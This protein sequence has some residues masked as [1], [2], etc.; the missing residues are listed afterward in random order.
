MWFRH[1]IPA[2]GIGLALLGCGLADLFSAAKIGDVSITYTGPDMVN[3]GDTVPL[4]VIVTAG[5]TPMTDVLLSVTSSDT[6]IIGLSARSD[7]F[8]A[9]GNGNE[10]LTIRV[11]ASIFT[12]T[13]PTLEQRIHVQP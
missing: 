10:T 4:T 7:T 3:V 2:I 13:F 8:Y 12:D 9:K 6:S 11:V 1:R 5:G